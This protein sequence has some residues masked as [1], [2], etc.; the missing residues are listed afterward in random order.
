MRDPDER[1]GPLAEN[2]ALLKLS[3]AVSVLKDF[4]P[5]PAVEAAA[6]CEAIG[7]TFGNDDRTATGFK[8]VHWTCDDIP[9]KRET[10]FNK[11]Y[12]QAFTLLDL[13]SPACQ[14]Y[15]GSHLA[16]LLEPDLAHVT[17]GDA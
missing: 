2:R 6:V 1:G 9:I 7:G 3:V 16:G 15:S 14:R 10:D 4:H 11:L 17:C 5:F 12:A 8:I 13:F